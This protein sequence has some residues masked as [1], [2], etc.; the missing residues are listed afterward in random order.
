MH[1]VEW[2]RGKGM[3]AFCSALFAT[4]FIGVLTLG[5]TP[6][7]ADAAVSL[8]WTN[9][10][11]GTTITTFP[12]G[13]DGFVYILVGVECSASA[14]IWVQTPDPPN[15]TGGGP[16]DPVGGGR[17]GI[18][19]GQPTVSNQGDNNASP[20]N[21]STKTP[22][23]T[24]G[25]SDPAH[26]SNKA[27]DPVVFSTGN[28][29]EPEVDFASAGEMGLSL[30]RTY[31]HYWNGIGIFGRRWLSDYDYKLLFTTTDPTSPCY[32]RPGNTPCDPTGK[33]IWALRPDGRQ[34]KFNYATTP[35]PGWYED[36]PSPVAKI[37]KTGSTYTLYSED[38]TVETY[39]A[40]GFAS[41]IHDQQGVGWTFT[42]DANHYLTRVTHTSGRHVDFGW[43]N[44]QLTQITDPAG[45]V[46]TYGYTSIPVSADAAASTQAMRPMLQYNPDPGA[47]D[48]P[49]PMTS[50]PTP[51]MVA[52]L[53]RATQP[54][55]Q[56]GAPATVTTY[57][58]EDSRFV[59]ALTGKSIN[60]SRYSWISY[61]ANAMATETHLAGGVEDYQFA[62]TLDS[63]GHIT[64]T[65]MTNPLG[66]QTVYDFNA[67]GDLTG[68]TG[69][70]ST[71]CSAAAKGY[72]YD[73]N[74]YLSTAIDF[75]GN[76]TTYAYSAKGQ[77]QKKVEG[78]GTSVQRT[79]D[80]VWDATYNR[81]TQVKVEGDHE[82][83]YGY[84]A[85]NH[86]TTVAVKNL[87]SAVAASQGQVHTTT[88]T[89]TGWT[90]G[91]LKTVVV[92]GPL[93]GSADQVTYSYSDTGDLLSEK[94]ALGQTTTYGNYNAL[95]LPG[96][97]T[98]TNGERVDYT[99]D[100]RG[101]EVDEATHRNGGTQ[102]T[103][104]EYDGFGRLSRITYPD[105]RTHAYQ[106]DVAGR[107]T[108]EFEPEG[109]GTFDETTYAYNALSLPVTVTK[110]RVFAEPQRGT[111]Q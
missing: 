100:A 83:T 49:P 31:D 109:D 29:I 41:V 86:L 110:Q 57:H 32:T 74:G 19:A 108:A 97:V 4:L 28:E 38:H 60:G 35:T 95:G 33:P 62:Y 26:G 63:N 89:Y 56:Q 91:L 34:I 103:T 10:E 67:Q 94:N 25:S 48:D 14:Y 11:C 72:A 46:Y 105:G 53:T 85:D 12:P 18:H 1:M 79:T 30:T 21:T 64:S 98:G 65:T 54:A 107:L 9:P 58:Y 69:A 104:Y 52:L 39:D 6:R 37:V 96:F 2:R 42:Y 3:K 50:D 7:T 13:P 81:P 78:W 17:G 106:Y 5:V 102:H 51:S 87:S 101:R 84:D 59:T 20:R 68:I 61:D 47:I 93:A 8:Q 90:N 92:D 82:T 73:D 16:S 75:D 24:A 23:D 43:N 55:T 70:P 36:K 76:T 80:Y 99:Y 71:H 77:L 111:V 66:K 22:C 15:G 45:N 27:G 40:S 88:Y 44:G